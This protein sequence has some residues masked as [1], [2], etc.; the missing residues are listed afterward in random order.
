MPMYM[1]FHGTNDGEGITQRPTDFPTSTMAERHNCSFSESLG[2]FDDAPSQIN[3]ATINKYGDYSFNKSSGAF[4]DDNL[5][6]NKILM[7][8]LMMIFS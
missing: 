8:H 2:A 6:S 4:D 1:P 7:L 3:T 5:I